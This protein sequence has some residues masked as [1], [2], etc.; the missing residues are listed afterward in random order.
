MSDLQRARITFDLTLNTLRVS[1]FKVSLT[2]LLGVCRG[3]GAQPKASVP[4]ESVREATAI[5]MSNIINISNR[6]PVTIKEGK[7]HS[8]SGGLVSALEGVAG[9]HHTLRRIGWPG[10]VP[11]DP[12]ARAELGRKLREEF[13]CIPVFLTDTEV[14]GY[15]AGF[16]NVSLWPLLHYMP[17]KFRFERDWWEQYRLVNERFADAALGVAQ[18]G[19][20]VWVH[21]YHLMLLPAMLK[22][23]MPS[24]KIGFFL[25]TPFPS[26]EIFRYNPRRQ[27]LLAG[28]LGADQIGFHTFQYLRHFRSAVLR[29]LGMDSEATRIRV[30]GHT[31]HLGVYPIGINAPRF[32][33]ALDSPEFHRET[34]ELRQSFGGKRVI[35]SVE[36]LDYTKGILQRLEAIDLF[37]AQTKDCENVRF[38]FVSVPSRED[39]DEYK[40]LREEV[41][42]RVGRL[43]G[44]YSTLHNTPIHFIHGSVEFTRLCAMYALTDV[45]LVTPL[46]DGM[47]LV[48]KEFVACQGGNPGVLV[49]S[50]FAGAAEELFNAVVVNPYDAQGVADWITAALAM[51]EPERRERMAPMIERVTQ[52]DA[53][54]WA[55]MFI[56]DLESRPPAAPRATSDPAALSAARE[57]MVTAI[58][59][60]R[61]TALF[62]DYDGTLRE[63]ERDPAAAR[64]TPALLQLFD[65][66]RDVSDLDVTLISGRRARDMEAWFGGL[67]FALIAEH[68][69]DMRRPG[70]RE[71]DPLDLVVNFDWKKDVRK[72][73]R[74]YADL[75]PGS[76]IE[77]KRT[78]LVWHY[79]KADPEFG[80]MKA[81]QLVEE[82]STLLANDPVVIRHGKKIVEIAAAQINKGAAVARILEEK[83]YDVALCA[84]DDQ[85]D[86]SMFALRMPNLI[87]MKV[88]WGDTAAQLRVPDPAALRGFLTDLVEQA[89]RHEAAV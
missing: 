49:L 2:R 82:L 23:R 73:L 54:W 50:E 89:T 27:E 85:T 46:V 9:E 3:M 34:A 76:F 4:G 56:D 14:E 13:D 21:D 19:D 55:R 24:L 69:A 81:N 84:G 29:M 39:V 79:R 66:L 86:E 64:P 59:F 5:R 42:Y 22:E 88:G 65:R 33:G 60:G 26:S 77:D 80:A 52:C 72:V 25:H 43:N 45:A 67:P 40:S 30:D 58:H 57:Q 15:Y 10:Q 62:L 28:L 41:E 74:L 35:F 37:L 8:S 12:A 53:A 51:P 87:T 48:A 36:R 16:S 63:L 17:S 6:L 70:S 18:E 47:N 68:G 32:R 20:L 71:W 83:R 11:D 31:A 78:G 7:I 44:K 75:T 38:V 61:P 1:N